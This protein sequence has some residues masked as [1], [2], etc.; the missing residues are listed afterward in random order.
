MKQYQSK[1]LCKQKDFTH[2]VVYDCG[3]KVESE[4]GGSVHVRNM[5]CCVCLCGEGVLGGCIKY[6]VMVVGAIKTKSY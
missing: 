2:T 6:V 3:R 4:R 5:K 1:L